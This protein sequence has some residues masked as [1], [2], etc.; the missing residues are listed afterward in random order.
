MQDKFFYSRKATLS[1]KISEFEIPPMQDLLIIGKKAPIGPE[2]VKRMAQALSPEQF[3]IIKLEHAKIEAV[4]IRDS[5][6]QMLD[7][8]VLMQIIL[9]EADRS[10]SDN[11]VLRSELKISISVQREVEL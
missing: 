8:R 7:E 9:E 10:I 5:L 2:A 1:L 6:L 11:M 4:L 3:T